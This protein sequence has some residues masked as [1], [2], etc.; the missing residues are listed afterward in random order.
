MDRAKE[1]S[2]RGY[3]GHGQQRVHRRIGGAVALR[4]RFDRGVR[5][6]F[7]SRARGARIAP[8][9]RELLASAR[10]MRVRRARAPLASCIKASCDIFARTQDCDGQPADAAPAAHKAMTTDK[11]AI[12]RA[13]LAYRVVEMSTDECGANFLITEWTNMS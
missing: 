2:R 12:V 8:V 1:S 5:V 6:P 11:R 10:V 9:G 4:A 13:G 7:F 3:S